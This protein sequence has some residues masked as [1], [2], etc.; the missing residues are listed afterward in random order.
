MG[1]KDDS[2]GCNH[3]WRNH[4]MCYNENHRSYCAVMM[5]SQCHETRHT[6]E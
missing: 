3:I 4:G 2:G 6:A 5:C 1:K